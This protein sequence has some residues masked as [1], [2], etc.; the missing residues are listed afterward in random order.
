LWKLPFNKRNNEI[1]N[2]TTH[3]SKFLKSLCEKHHYSLEHIPGFFFREVPYDNIE[4]PGL[5]IQLWLYD[6]ML[7]EKSKHHY[8]HGFPTI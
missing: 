1:S 4:S 3:E 6:Q 5:L 2:L 8:K 7:I